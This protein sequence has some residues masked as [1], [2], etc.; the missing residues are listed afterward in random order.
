M[1]NPFTAM[2]TLTLRLTMVPSIILPL[3][4]SL[5]LVHCTRSTWP[6]FRVLGSQN[7][8]KRMQEI[9]VTSKFHG[10]C[11]YKKPKMLF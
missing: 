1:N 11:K 10:D 2:R 8:I 9:T 5:Y 6:K 7:F 4:S 3:L